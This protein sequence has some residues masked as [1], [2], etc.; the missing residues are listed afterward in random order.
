MPG[1]SSWNGKWSGEGC[2]YVKR[3]IINNG[4]IRTLAEKNSQEEEV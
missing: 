1:V 4:R 2:K 3:E